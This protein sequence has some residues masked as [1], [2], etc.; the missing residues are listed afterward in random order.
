M[1]GRAMANR[2]YVALNGE[3]LGPMSDTGLE[4]MI[5]GGR[6]EG[7]TLVRNGTASDWLP[8]REAEEILAARPS[9]Q[10]PGDA[11]I[12]AAIESK[13]AA[14]S[15]PPPPSPTTPPPPAQPPHP[16]AEDLSDALPA[17]DDLSTTGRPP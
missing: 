2:W 4:R 3:E 16:P 1:R 8:A 9:R 17:P 14:A 10:R 5:Q 7:E 12:H 6:I 13:R 15:L 11:A